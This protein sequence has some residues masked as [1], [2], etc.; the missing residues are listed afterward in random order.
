MMK[1]KHLSLRP[2][3]LWKRFLSARV[4]QD[5]FYSA[6]FALVLV[7]STAL[8]YHIVRQYKDLGALAISALAA[9][10]LWYFVLSVRKRQSATDRFNKE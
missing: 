2:Y 8:F 4:A 10:L 5:L 1:K 6:G 9:N 7:P 3:E